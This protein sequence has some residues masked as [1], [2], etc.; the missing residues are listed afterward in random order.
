[1]SYNVYIAELLYIDINVVKMNFLGKSTDI[2]RS[3][4]V[5]KYIHLVKKCNSCIKTI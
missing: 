4:N 1:M 3:W 5:T 2:K